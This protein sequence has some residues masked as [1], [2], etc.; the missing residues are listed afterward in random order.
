MQPWTI[1]FTHAHLQILHFY[2]V[3]IFYLV[4]KLKLIPVVRQYNTRE[5][6]RCGDKKLLLSPR[7]RCHDCDA[8]IAPTRLRKKKD[9]LV[10][11]TSYRGSPIRGTRGDPEY[12]TFVILSPKL[13]L[14]QCDY[15]TRFFSGINLPHVSLSLSFCVRYMSGTYRT[16]WSRSP[17]ENCS[18]VQLLETRGLT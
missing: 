4:K 11:R 13:H 6:S 7:L 3:F 18:R 1:T 14:G 9:R 15:Y 2:K 8:A 12:V 16:K 10:G 17:R 5:S